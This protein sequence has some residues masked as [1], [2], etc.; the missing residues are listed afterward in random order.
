MRKAAT[1]AAAANAPPPPNPS[2]LAQQEPARV[3]DNTFTIEPSIAAASAPT[4]DLGVLAILLVRCCFV[5]NEFNANVYCG[6]GVY[7]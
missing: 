1:T 7:R 5:G 3:F 6:Q 2:T 4:D